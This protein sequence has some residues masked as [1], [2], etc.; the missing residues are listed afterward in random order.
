ML[1]PST[2]EKMLFVRKRLGLSQGR[3]N[4]YAGFPKGFYQRIERGIKPLSAGHFK[5][6]VNA[7]RCRLDESAEEL[8]VMVEQMSHE[9]QVI[10]SEE[11]K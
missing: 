4:Q 8:S 3:V 7:F 10:V 5:M 11:E 9:L 1:S 6:I 2:I